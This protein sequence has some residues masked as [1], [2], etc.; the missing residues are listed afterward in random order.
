MQH[1]R[2][3]MA[4][5]I[6][7]VIAAAG[8][9]FVKQMNAKI[10]GGIRHISFPNT[11]EALAKM[12]KHFPKDEL[13]HNRPPRKGLTGVVEPTT[14]VAYDYHALDP[15]GS[16]ERYGVQSAPSDAHAGKQLK[17]GGP[18]WRTYQDGK[19]P[20]ETAGTPLPPWCVKYYKEA[21]IWPSN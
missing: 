1:W 17:E 14:F 19:A 13:G 18:L 6:D 7:W 4:G 2:A 15:Q 16:V 21:G 8:S 5:K 9:G 11:P 20:R 3:F 10:D 12:R